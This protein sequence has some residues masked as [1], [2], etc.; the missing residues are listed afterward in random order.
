MWVTVECHFPTHSPV[1]WQDVADLSGA[2]IQSLTTPWVAMEGRKGFVERRRHLCRALKDEDKKL[3]VTLPHHLP[4]AQIH[5]SPHRWPLSVLEA[6]FL[7]GS[8]IFL[9]GPLGE[10]RSQHTS[11]VSGHQ[12]I[13]AGV[14]LLLSG[15]FG[16][17]SHELLC[18]FRPLVLLP[19]FS[20]V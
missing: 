16:H 20:S 7:L 6:V 2:G 4:T 8:L 9:A 19:S 14:G 13:S 5:T 10:G 1:S 11:T 15:Q 3:V 12:A 18:F 17:S